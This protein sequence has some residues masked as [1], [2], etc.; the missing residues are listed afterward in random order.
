MRVAIGLRSAMK[1]KV[2]NAGKL[3]LA[4][5]IHLSE[6]HCIDLGISSAPLRPLHQN[7]LLHSI[8]TAGIIYTP[9]AKTGS[10]SVYLAVFHRE[11]R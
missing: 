1:P 7:L 8:H 11:A 6:G 10:E 4:A 3:C 9:P 2:P 5:A